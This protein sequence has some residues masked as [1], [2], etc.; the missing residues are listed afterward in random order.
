MKRIS[1]IMKN[2]IVL[3]GA[4]N[5][6]SQLS[7]RL[8]EAA[9]EIVQVVSRSEMSAKTLAEKLETNFTTEIE[10]IDNSADL[11]FFA[12]ADDAIATILEKLPF[13]N[14]ILVH[15]AGSVGID[16][17]NGFANDYGVFYPLQTFAKNKRPNFGEIPICIEANSTE[18]KNLLWDIASKI[19][20]NVKYISSEER[21]KIH[22]A[23]VFV[24]NFANHM[25]VVSESILN[26]SNLNFDI[27]KPLIRETVSKIE[28][29]SPTKMQTGPAFRGDE[30]TI[31]SHLQILKKF[32][33]YYETYKFLSEKII[34]QKNG[35]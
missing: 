10:K 17:F 18:I 16:I 9:Y 12:V 1:K 2:K 3:I 33:E 31:N 32:P 28:N 22:L 30:K 24:C 20:E 5:L 26:C 27:L 35:I 13:K 19:S 21:K 6:A 11:Y 29:E 14:K 25:F 15:T 23:A 4:G 34:N 8:Q 7:L